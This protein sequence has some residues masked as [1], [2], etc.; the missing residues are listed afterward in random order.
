M[1]WPSTIAFV[2]LIAI[3]LPAY[4]QDDGFKD[5]P[6]DTSSETPAKVSAAPKR[7]ARP[8]KMATSAIAAAAKSPKRMKRRMWTLAYTSWT[9]SIKL[10][11]DDGAKFDV[12]EQVWGL[13]AGYNWI[14]YKNRTGRLTSA[15][16]IGGQSAVESHDPQLDFFRNKETVF[17]A[18]A[19]HG[20]YYI[21]TKPNIWI[22]ALANVNLLHHA[23]HKPAGYSLDDEA[24]RYSVYLKLDLSFP[25]AKNIL[26]VQQLGIPVLNDGTYWLIGVRFR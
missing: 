3:A 21:L 25:V 17:G 26:V 16:L 6:G 11:R 2:A 5:V 14:T 8:S 13:T 10:K 24:N 15:E 12:A 4:A 9:D 1:A 7:S 18:G 19:S 23:Y 22:G 20:Y